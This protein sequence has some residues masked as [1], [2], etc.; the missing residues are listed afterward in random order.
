MDSLLTS[1]K[2]TI[3]ANETIAALS[4][5]RIQIHDPDTL[6]PED[7]HRFAV[8]LAPARRRRYTRLGGQT[9]RYLWV[10]V[11]AWKKYARAPDQAIMGTGNELGLDDF[12]DAV[13]EAL[14]HSALGDGTLDTPDADEALGEGEYLSGVDGLIGVRYEFAARRRL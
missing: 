4:N 8:V 5:V 10:T 13:E 11:V 1:L 3:E 12:A 9:H 6:E 14:T 2:E 7:I